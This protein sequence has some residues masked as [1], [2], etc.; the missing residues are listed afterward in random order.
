MKKHRGVLFPSLIT[1]ITL[2]V[3]ISTNAS[4]SNDSGKRPGPPPPEAIDACKEKEVGDVVTF[5]GRNG[6]KLQAVCK[7]MQGQLVAVPDNMPSK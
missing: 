6:E 1:L 4:A 5:A 2:I 3:M 7:D